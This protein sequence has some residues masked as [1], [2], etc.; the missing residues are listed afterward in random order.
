VK[1]NVG[2]LARNLTWSSL[3]N[4]TSFA[5]GGKRATLTTKGLWHAGEYKVKQKTI[6]DNCYSTLSH[7]ITLRFFEIYKCNINMT[8][9]RSKRISVFQVNWQRLR[10]ILHRPR[11]PSVFKPSLDLKLQSAQIVGLILI[12]LWA[13]AAISRLQ[14]ADWQPGSTN[15]S[16]SEHRRISREW[17]LSNQVCAGYWRG[18]CPDSSP[19]FELPW[20]RNG[21][22]LGGND[23]RQPWKTTRDEREAIPLDW[24][25]NVMAHNGFSSQVGVRKIATVIAGTR[26]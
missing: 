19:V 3:L 2:N 9:H 26:I 15:D 10:P 18:S 21:H 25:T 16:R 6:A 24:R 4:S 12:G 22:T 17:I 14:A 1:V 7:V 13:G 11:T 8:T 20:S 23:H 5:R